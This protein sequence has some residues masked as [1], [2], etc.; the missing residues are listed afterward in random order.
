MHVV[1]IQNNLNPTPYVPPPVPPI[2]LTAN[3]PTF[4]YV[5]DWKARSR[6]LFYEQ[7][8]NK[9]NLT[10]FSDLV[11]SK[12]QEI[13]NVAQTLFTLPSIDL[14]VGSQLDVLGRLIGQLRNGVDDTTYRLYLRARIRVNR[15]SGTV[16]NIYDVF[17]AML[18][19]AD[20]ELI[21][22]YPAGFELRID[23]PMPALEAAVA[24]TFLTDAKAAGVK[25]L[26]I[27]QQ[28]PD[29]ET[30]TFALACFL[31]ANAVATDTTLTVDDTS[32]LPS[33]GSVTLDTG[34]AIAETRTYTV[35]SSTLLTLGAGLAFNHDIGS[36][37]ELVGDLGKGFGDSTDPLVGGDFSGVAVA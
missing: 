24:L 29:A 22:R 30:F 34:S 32:V 23:T 2:E 31:T 17:N 8:K 11:A 15:S 36:A 3:Q 4:D 7:F 12:F 18:D 25:G 13:E 35:T 20:Q 19:G 1:L 6:A 37:V 9:A 5:A 27:W 26:L 21:E 16:Q 10:A 14:S 33:T 28:S